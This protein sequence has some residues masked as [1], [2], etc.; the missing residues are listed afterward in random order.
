MTREQFAKQIHWPFFIWLMGIINAVALFPQLW[1]VIQ[2]HRVESFSL[3]TFITVFGIQVAFSL[4]GFFKHNV[5]LL[6]SN[7][8]AAVM[9]ASLISLVVY[10]RNVA[11]G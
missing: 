6:I 4:D 7:G 2:T 1:D 11:G 8:C 10:Y 9:N 5:V 3:T